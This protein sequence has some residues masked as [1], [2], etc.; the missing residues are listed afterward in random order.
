MRFLVDECTGPAVA[1]WLRS[2][3]HDVFSIFEEARGITDNQI[4]KKAFEEQ[5]ILLTN[6]KDF[7]EKVYKNKL[8]HCG[9]ILLRLQDERSTVKIDIIQKLLNEYANDISGCFVIVTEHQVRFANK[10]T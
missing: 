7:G 10:K 8:P 1:L 6:D 2:Q 4:I 3:G 5:R 9:V